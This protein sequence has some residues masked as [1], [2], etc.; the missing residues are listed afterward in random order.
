MSHELRYKELTSD[1]ITPNS[2][3]DINRLLPQLSSSAAPCTA[4]WLRYVLASGTRIF[5]ALDGET[6]VGTVLLC[7]AVILVGQKDWIEDVVV[8]EHYRGQGIASRLMDMAEAASRAGKAKSLNLTSATDRG[9]ARDLYQKR[10]YV[11]RDTGVFRLT[12]ER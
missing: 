11:L 4:D 3:A 12:H 6:V 5:A 1:D 9:G 8:D 2:V 10:G 7:S